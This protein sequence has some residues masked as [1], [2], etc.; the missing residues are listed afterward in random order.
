MWQARAGKRSPQA[1]VRIAVD[2]ADAGVI[3]AAEALARVTDEHVESLA[4]SSQVDGADGGA[5]LASG[6]GASPGVA[7]G[8]VARDLDEVL[9]L[10]DAGHAVILVRTFTRSEEH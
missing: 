6:L 8:H 1:A 7:T 3:T 2:L 4:N 9:A 5:P 10:T